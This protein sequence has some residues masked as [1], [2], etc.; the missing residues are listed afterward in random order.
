MYR[1]DSKSRVKFS[2]PRAKSH[3]AGEQIDG[4]QIAEDV[5]ALCAV[6]ERGRE[7]SGIR[8]DDVTERCG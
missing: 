8:N 1:Q 5:S 6:L 7:I 4:E 3:H 2:P